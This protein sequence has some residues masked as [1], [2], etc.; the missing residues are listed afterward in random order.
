MDMFFDDELIYEFM[1]LGSPILY[2]TLCYRVPLEKISNFITDEKYIEYDKEK[3]ELLEYE[4]K[5]PKRPLILKSQNFIDFIG[6]FLECLKIM[7]NKDIKQLFKKKLR[8][9]DIETFIE[10][11]FKDEYETLINVNLCKKKKIN[12]ASSQGAAAINQASS[13]LKATGVTDQLRPLVNVAFFPLRWTVGAINFGLRK[14]ENF[15]VSNLEEVIENKFEKRERIETNK[16]FI[17]AI[18]GRDQNR[19]LRILEE[20]IK[21]GRNNHINLG[22][23]IIFR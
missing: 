7:E 23:K 2:G 14:S 17:N 20:D 6:Y 15:V 4:D 19:I 16:E 8:G 1:I 11:H 12:G 13:I 9:S 21:R 22:Q 5:E 18:R 3:K 10:E